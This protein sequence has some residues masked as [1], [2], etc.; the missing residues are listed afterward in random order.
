MAASRTI[1]LRTGVLSDTSTVSPAGDDHRA[2][3]AAGALLADPQDR[4][5]RFLFERPAW[6]HLP[7]TPGSVGYA[8]R[9]ANA[10]PAE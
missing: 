6:A 3:F 10:V 8:K 1:L 4:L 9:A 5:G 7:G 2:R